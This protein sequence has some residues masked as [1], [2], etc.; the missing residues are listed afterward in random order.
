MQEL[1]ASLTFEGQNVQISE[2]LAGPEY[3]NGNIKISPGEIIG[4]TPN[5]FNFSN[6]QMGGVRILANDWD[7]M[8][9]DT[10]TDIHVNSNDNMS[11]G[12]DIANWSPCQYNG[13]PSVTE[14]GI[15][16]DDTLPA[17]EGDCLYTTKHNLVLKDT[18]NTPEYYPDAS[19][20]I[21]MVQYSDTNETR[22][23]SQDFFRSSELLLED[24]ECL[25]NPSMSGSDFN[26]NECLV[27]ILPGSSQIIYGK[28]DPQNTWQKTLQGQNP[29]SPVI[30][31]NHIIVMEVNKNISP[32]TTFNCRMRVNFSN[33]SDCFDDENGN[34]YPDYMHA[35][36]KPFKLINFSFKVLN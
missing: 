2:G 17:S 15:V 28:I 8:K 16:E 6:S 14:G 35:G 5:L 13:W 18:S 4:I 1:L 26:P 21:C 9:L 22:W 27:R 24:N 19:Q 29:T 33:C 11:A 7:H 30:S 36:D 23:V 12:E 32:G 34:E 25:N 31:T 3:N 10:S 20:P